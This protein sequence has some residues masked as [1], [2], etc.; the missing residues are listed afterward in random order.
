MSQAIEREKPEIVRR[1]L[2][3]DTRITKADDQF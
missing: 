1:E 2:V 3:L